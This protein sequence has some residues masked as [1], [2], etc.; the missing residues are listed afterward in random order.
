MKNL[1]QP[2]NYLA[3]PNLLVINRNYKIINLHKEVLVKGMY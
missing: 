3:N 1:N 2:Q